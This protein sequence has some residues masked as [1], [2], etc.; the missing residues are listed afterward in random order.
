MV[1]TERGMVVYLEYA[2][3]ENFIIDAGLIY[4]AVKAARGKTN[5]FRLLFAAAAGAVEAIVFPLLLLPAWAA[6]F[7][8]I[9]GGLLLTVLALKGGKLKTHAVAAITFFLFTFALGGL[10]TAAYS[11]FGVEAENGNGY[12]VESAPVGLV[13]AFSLLFF[14]AAANGICY[15]FRM[16]RQNRHRYEVEIIRGD[17]TV[18]WK[19]LSDS[20][21]ALSFRKKPVCVLS[22]VAAFALFGAH[23]KSV[24]RIE[25]NTVNGGAE[26]PVFVAEKMTVAKEEGF[27]TFENVYFTV[28]EVTG[29]EYQ[30]VLHTAFTEGD[31]EDS[32]GAQSV[33]KTD[34]RERKRRSLFKRK[35]GA[36]L[37]AFSRGRG[38][39]AQIHRGGEER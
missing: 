1:A 2:F 21:N 11:F 22:A 10:L 39:D 26:R 33:A 23:P 8:K 35:R 12:L 32:L 6:Y 16:R 37:A 34:G 5:A 17:T 18:K 24:G 31:Y 29:K 27:V 36:S 9:A 15:L 30:I 25:V 7:I 38:G 28:G 13:F 14:I 3:I 20:G 19:G 4:L